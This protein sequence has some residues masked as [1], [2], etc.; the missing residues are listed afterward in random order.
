MP[1]QNVEKFSRD[2]IDTYHDKSKHLTA[3]TAQATAVSHHAAVSSERGEFAIGNAAKMGRASIETY[4]EKVLDGVPR[5]VAAKEASREIGERF[6]SRGREV[7]QE[8]DRA[9]GLGS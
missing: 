8:R 7:K 2:V 9:Y 1:N 4:R 6:D 3:A 5:D